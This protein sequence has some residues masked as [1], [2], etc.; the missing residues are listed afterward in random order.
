MTL[1]PLAFVSTLITSAFVI[2]FIPDFEKDLFNS[3][4]ISTSSKGKI[5]GRYSIKVTS[6]P[7]L[8]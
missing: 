4:E 7:I 1:H 8:L 3:F 6:V 2:I 5:S